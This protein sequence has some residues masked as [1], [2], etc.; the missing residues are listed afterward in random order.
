MRRRDCL[1]YTADLKILQN[2]SKTIPHP[3]TREPP[4]HKGAFLF[5]FGAIAGVSF[6]GGF[7]SL[8]LC[9]RYADCIIPMVQDA[10]VSPFIS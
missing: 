10:Y 9:G 7:F 6:A 1:S 5:S 4:L 3:L 2:D 8:V